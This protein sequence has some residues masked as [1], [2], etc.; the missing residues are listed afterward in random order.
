[1]FEVDWKLWWGGAE[2]Q[3]L[4]SCDGGDA[5]G[6]SDGKGSLINSYIVV[7][8]DICCNSLTPRKDVCRSNAV[9]SEMLSRDAWN[10]EVVERKLFFCDPGRGR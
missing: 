3:N 1:M 2:L 4:V 7:N 9:A 6:N 5:N 8:S 10:Q